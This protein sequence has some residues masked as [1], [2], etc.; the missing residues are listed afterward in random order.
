MSGKQVKNLRKLVH[1]QGVTTT[2][3]E[4]KKLKRAW[5]KATVRERRVFDVRKAMA[6]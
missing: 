6:L 5:A 4:Q 1:A 3:R 2:R